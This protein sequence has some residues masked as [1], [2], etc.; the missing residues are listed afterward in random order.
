TVTVWNWRDDMRRVH[1]DRG[2]RRLSDQRH[3]RRP[4]LLPVLAAANTRRP[5]VEHL[6]LRLLHGTNYDFIKW[7]KHMA[8]LTLAWIAIGAGIVAEGVA[9]GGKAVNYSIEFTG[10]TLIQLRFAQPPHID[11]IRQTVADAGYAHA[12]IQQFGS[13]TEYTVRAPGATAAA[14]DSTAREIEAALKARYSPTGVSVPRSE[15]V[16]PRVGAELRRNAIIAI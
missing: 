13:P 6:M 16:G 14:G 11:D 9:T 15:Y 1:A 5:D 10:G 4:N 12:E 7:W 8:I 2:H 3:L